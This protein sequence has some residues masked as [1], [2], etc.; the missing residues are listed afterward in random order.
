VT[1]PLRFRGI[2]KRFGGRVALSGVDLELRAGE[3][4]A[5]LGENGA[6]KT[7]LVRIALGL[8]AADEGALQVD[9]RDVAIDHPRRAARLGIGMVH[10]HFSLAEGLT[11]AENLLLADAPALFSRRA[12]HE[13]AAERLRRRGVLLEPARRVRDLSVGER[14]RLEI[15]RALERA[16]RVL[17]LDEPT[18]VLAPAESD[19]LFAQLERLRAAGLAI[20]LITHQLDEALSIAQRVTV[21]RDGRV[22]L[23][24]S[25]GEVTADALARALFGEGAAAAAPSRRLVASGARG[26]PGATA[27]PVLRAERLAGERLGPVDLE[28]RAGEVTVVAG[29]DGNGQTELVETLAG[30]RRASSGR[31]ERPTEGVAFVSCDRQSTGLALDLPIAENVAVKRGFLARAWFTRRELEAATRP[32]LQR[33]DVRASGPW[34]P[35]RTLSGGNQQKLVLAR[36]LAHEPR[37]V[38]AENPTRGLDLRATAFVRGELQA[39]AARGAAA[40]VATTDV[41]EA[42]ELA[43]RLLIAHRGR[44]HPCEATRAAITRTMTELAAGGRS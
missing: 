16:G 39:A 40:L 13:R 27:A 19:E 15:A 37:L 6:G 8:L 22:A 31:L 30:L 34:Q 32:A 14:Q 9:G 38:L 24:A 2:G 42:L 26:M 1:S 36:E 44:L 29:V 11:V 12:L 7:T 35:A 21:L 25:R 18:A 23:A 41:D 5:L 3:V 43:D 17:I 28:L 4:H 10:Q 20:L 33:F